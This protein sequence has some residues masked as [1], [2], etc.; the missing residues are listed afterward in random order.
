MDFGNNGRYSW[1]EKPWTLSTLKGA[2]EGWQT[3]M[4][5]N[6][7]WNS[8]CL[9]SHDQ[10]RSVSRFVDRSLTDNDPVTRVRV[11]K[12]LATLEA[13]QCGTIYV[14]QGQELAMKNM[15]T[16]WPIEEYKDVETQNAYKE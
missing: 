16:H 9:E 6:G 14:Y 13:G 12:M 8:V 1:P 3:F 5:Q 2:L 11:A 4:I 15:P 7:G 10:P